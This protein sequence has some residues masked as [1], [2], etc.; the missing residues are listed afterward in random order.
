[1]ATDAE[2]LP[3]GL[4]ARILTFTGAMTLLFA[5]VG[6]AFQ[7]AAA[8]FDAADFGEPAG[9]VFDLVLA[10]E[11]GLRHK[12]GAAG[13]AFIVLVAVVGD[14]WMATVCR[15]VALEAAGWRRGA[16]GERRLDDCAAAVAAQFVEDGLKTGSAGAV[17]AELLAA[18]VGVAAIQGST[19]AACADVL[20]LE[21]GSS[22][23]SPC[24]LLSF[25]RFL[26]TSAA[27]F[28]ALV[29]S[30]VETS[31]ANTHAL[32]RLNH[33]LMAYGNRRGAAASTCNLHLLPTRWA[34][35]LMARLLALMPTIKHLP[36]RL[37][38]TGDRVL[39]ARPDLVGDFTKACF[40]TW[41]VSD[42]VG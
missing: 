40:T 34:L 4:L 9:L 20:C 23:V 11:A 29:S 30:T 10:A 32:R 13:A 25:R 21:L 2:F 19:T 16:A 31:L 37:C 5:E 42:D 26:L 38:A 33:T 28:A 35:A 3:A 18:V 15:A 6:A 7:F 39:T 24:P 36:A 17:V 22:T 12:E 8:D 27:P 41:T 1:M 14:R